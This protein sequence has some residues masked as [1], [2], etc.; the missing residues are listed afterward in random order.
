[1][2]FALLA[3]AAFAET[4]LGGNMK[5]G[6]TI[7]KGQSKENPTVVPRGVQAG[8]VLLWDAFVNVNFGDAEGGGMMRL[9][10]KTNE[11]QPDI[12]AYYWWRPVEYFRMQVG[13]N[14]DGDWGT[15][16]ITG[17]GYNGEPQGANVALDAHRGLNGTNA[18]VARTAGFWGGTNEL[19]MNLSGYLLDSALTLNVWVPFGGAATAWQNVYSKIALNVVYN[20]EEV[21]KVF[22]TAEFDKGN[23]KKIDPIEIEKNRLDGKKA[24]DYS[25]RGTSEG[26]DP[27]SVYASAFI[28]AI[29]NMA[30]DLGFAYT[31]PYS[32]YKPVWV[33]GKKYD[34]D[35]GGTITGISSSWGG[36]VEKKWIDDSPTA[37]HWEG[38]AAPSG[39]YNAGSAADTTNI[40][41]NIGGYGSSGNPVNT[42]NAEPLRIGL[43][44]RVGVGSN[45][46]L[47]LRTGFEIA[48][49]QTRKD[50]K[51]NDDE[52]FRLY[53]D[54]QLSTMSNTTLAGYLYN[55]TRE[56]RYNLSLAS[57]L[58]N[59]GAVSYNATLQGEENANFGYYRLYAKTAA[60]TAPTTGPLVG[61]GQRLGG[62]ILDENGKVTGKPVYYEGTT[63]RIPNDFVWGLGILPSYKVGKATL[64]LNAGIGLK[65]YG[66]VEIT[67]AETYKNSITGED[68]GI[69]KFAND[70]V[71]YG[72]TTGAPSVTRAGAVGA[73]GEVGNIVTGKRKIFNT[74]RIVAK[75]ATLGSFAEFMEQENLRL[76][77][78][79]NPAAGTE[80]IPGGKLSDDITAKTSEVDWFINPYVVIPAGGARIYFGFKLYDDASGKKAQR[81]S[82]NKGN[83]ESGLAGQGTGRFTNKSII[84]WE[85]PIGF[86]F[87]L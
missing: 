51:W 42:R 35:T 28:T 18:I 15:A 49:G 46:N 63:D 78:P 32:T 73:N 59:L 24:K 71:T 74:E 13:K 77:D 39:I 33:N 19:G 40:A 87:Y 11:W 29:D 9:W 81:F 8:G 52:I 58:G 60:I 76:Q 26:H 67:Y 12:F 83:L 84:K 20:I 34:T 61:T 21:G 44:Y 27:F 79:S 45:F 66:K 25:W 4:S 38:I 70:D 37:G 30:I 56:K 80:W 41:V 82:Y 72:V 53:M 43:G 22:L 86:N 85:I 10:T 57:R 3:T 36:S 14:P 48:G 69:Y 31:L 23:K 7:L 6:T 50:G 2:L 5:I 65:K 47:K 62:T 1:M 54:N 55:N 68:T 16:Q 64:F 17:W 75:K